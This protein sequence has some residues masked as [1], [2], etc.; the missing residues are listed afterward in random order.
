MPAAAGVLEARRG[1][2]TFLGRQFRI[3]MGEVI[4]Y[5]D[6][7][8]MNPDLDLN[9]TV[10]VSGILYRIKLTG[11]A[12]SPRLRLRSEPE[13]TEADI[14][15]GLLFGK[16]MADLDSSEESL[17][18]E[19]TMAI[20]ASFG[21]VA[22]QDELSR[23]LGVDL[24]SYG[25]STSDRE[26]SSLTVGKFLSPKVMVKYE[27]VL[28]AESAFYVHLDYSLHRNI[29]VQT[30]VSQGGRSGISLMWAKDY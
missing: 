23:E 6:E 15:S 7:V 26:K 8:K 22:L 13:M 12:Q 10:T 29:D 28:D 25:H 30:T 27:Q 18:R 4:F 9:L 2:L 24:V 21:A 11:P 19:R 1:Y 3:E 14:I 17:M 20:L 16:P 5:G